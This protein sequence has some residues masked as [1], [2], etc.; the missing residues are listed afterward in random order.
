MKNNVKTRNWFVADSRGNL[1]GHDLDE[2]TARQCERQ[3]KEEEPEAEWE[4]MQADR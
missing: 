1:A 3:M 4:A 2:E